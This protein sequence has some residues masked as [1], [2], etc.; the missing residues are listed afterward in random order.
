[1]I[2]TDNLQHLLSNYFTLVGGSMTEAE[3]TRRLSSIE[4]LEDLNAID[5]DLEDPLWFVVPQIIMHRFGLADFQAFKTQHVINKSFVLVH[6][7]NNH[8]VP[9]LQESLSKHWIVC[10]PVTRELTGQL[11]C[12]LYGGYSWHGAYAA[13]C[14]YRGDIGKQATILQL[15]PCTNPELQNLIIYKNNNRPHFAEKIIIEREH[16]GQTMDGMIQ[17]FH[18]PDLIENTRQLLNLGLAGRN[19]ITNECKNYFRA[20]SGR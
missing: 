11:I 2:D 4:V 5:N 14:K 1:M 6:P 3:L 20:H 9:K 12:F 17:A 19:E 18:C 16:I 8:I 13:A 15:E 7:A 10:E